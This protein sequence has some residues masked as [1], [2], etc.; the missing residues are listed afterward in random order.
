MYVRIIR[1]IF[2]YIE[3]FFFHRRSNLEIL[4][5]IQFKNYDDFDRRSFTNHILYHFMT[6]KTIK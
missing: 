2:K 6:R 5:I 4:Y 3:I 1:T